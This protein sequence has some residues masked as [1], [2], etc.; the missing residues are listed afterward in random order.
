MTTH[1]LAKKL[2][3]G[4]NLLVTISG[5]EGGS[6]EITHISEPREIHL[7]VYTAWYYGEHEFHIEGICRSCSN[8]NPDLPLAINIGCSPLRKGT[9]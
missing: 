5:Y 8:K 6:N 7:S 3:E 1:E 4:P 2:L 9:L